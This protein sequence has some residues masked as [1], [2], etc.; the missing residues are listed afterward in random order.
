L[1]K[2]ESQSTCPG[3]YERCGLGTPRRQKAHIILVISSALVTTS[4]GGLLAPS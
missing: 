4:I 3:S 2:S 1:T